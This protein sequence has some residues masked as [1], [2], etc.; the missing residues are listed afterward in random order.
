MGNKN[1]LILTA[2]NKFRK[3]YSGILIHYMEDDMKPTVQG[4]VNALGISRFTQHDRCAGKT[5]GV[6]GD[7]DVVGLRKYILM[8]VG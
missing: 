2:M 4:L 6:N 1:S 5:H 7:A 8:Q 3:E